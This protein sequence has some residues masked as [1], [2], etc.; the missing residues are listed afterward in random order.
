LEE[1]KT[2]SVIACS[3]SVSPQTSS[4]VIVGRCLFQPNAVHFPSAPPARCFS[5]TYRLVEDLKTDHHNIWTFSIVPTKIQITIMSFSNSREREPTLRKMSSTLSNLSNADAEKVMIKRTDSMGANAKEGAP[6]TEEELCDIINSLHNITPANANID[7]EALRRLLADIAHLS[8][9]QW[10]LT[11]ENST[12]MAQILTPNGLTPP[13][14]QQI[15]E[16]ILHEGNWD[17]ALTHAKATHHGGT[18]PWA[19]LVTGVNGI[20]K[21]TAMY[22]PWF[23]QLLKEALVAPHG[24]DS[25]FDTESLPHGNNSFFRQLDHMITTLCNEDF[26]TL[27]A[28]TSAQLKGENS[29]K[30]PKELIRKYSNLKASIFS[31]YRTLSELLGALLLKEAQHVNINA[32]CETSGR[33]VAMFNYIDHFFPSGY[34]KLALHFTINDLSHAMRSVDARMVKEIKKGQEALKSENAIDVIYANAGG[35]YGSEVLAGVQSDSDRVWNEII[36]KGDGVSKDWYKATFHIE[37]H[38]KDPWKIYAVR[39]DGSR[40]TKYTFG[41]PRTVR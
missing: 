4:F 25:Q 27:Y 10:D 20:R 30:P 39:P 14:C 2:Q 21:T 24:V 29:D 11:E 7:W 19:V 12:K 17:G 31:R 26:S 33:D 35:P 28:L 1:D 3:C 40:G 15:F 16:R 41:E 34:N 6:L 5:P 32:M 18:K 9:K 22:E 23:P 36:M 37:A 13:E 38:A 8:H